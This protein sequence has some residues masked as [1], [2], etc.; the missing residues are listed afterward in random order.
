VDVGERR[1]VAESGAL[2]PAL[3]VIGLG[4]GAIRRAWRAF[5]KGQWQISEL[6][7]N[8]QGYVQGLNGWQRHHHEGYPP[9]SVAVTAFWR[10]KLKTCP[11]QHYH[12]AA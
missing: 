1:V 11:S 2:F 4:A 3:K 9:I 5:G 10:P 12:P 8:W 7:R 6:L